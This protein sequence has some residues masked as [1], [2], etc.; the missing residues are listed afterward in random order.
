MR[1]YLRQRVLSLLGL[2]NYDIYDEKGQLLF[3]AEQ[4]LR[5]PK[6]LRVY[7]AQNQHVGTVKRKL[8]RLQKTFVLTESE[9]ISEEIKKIG[10]WKKYRFIQRG[11]LARGSSF[12]GD[13]RIYSADGAPVAVIDDGRQGCT[14]EITGLENNL[15]VLL[16]ALAV[17]RKKNS[18]GI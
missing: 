12:V 2:R 18:I 4:Q 13:F 17:Q 8:L 5:I 6:E 14:M 7:N 15:T 16:F 1:L 10:F 3:V 11:W 9:N